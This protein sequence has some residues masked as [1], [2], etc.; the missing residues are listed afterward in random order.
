MISQSLSTHWMTKRDSELEQHCDPVRSTPYSQNDLVLQYILI[1][2][3]PIVVFQSNQPCCPRVCSV[4]FSGCMQVSS[5]LGYSC[6]GRQERCLMDNTLCHRT[7]AAF[8]VCHCTLCGLIFPLHRSV[9]QWLAQAC[10]WQL[11][12]YSSKARLAQKSGQ[13]PSNTSRATSRG[14]MV[15]SCPEYKHSLCC[16]LLLVVMACDRI[17]AGTDIWEWAPSGLKRWVQ[18]QGRSPAWWLH[19]N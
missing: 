19:Q 6:E 12:S 1:C 13:V 2:Q 16:F 4:S 5:C 10:K 9:A 17:S 8:V 11:T 18:G 7:Q 15:V 14:R 3:T